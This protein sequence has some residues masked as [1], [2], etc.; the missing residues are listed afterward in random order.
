M[1]DQSLAEIIERFRELGILDDPQIAGETIRIYLTEADKTIEA[2]EE[3]VRA[4]EAGLVERYAHKLRGGALNLGA[5]RL[6]Q[7][8]GS[9]EENGRSGDLSEAGSRSGQIRAEFAR[10]RLFLADL[11]RG[12][13][14]A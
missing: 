8:A 2:L 12:S 1:T 5:R 4:S 11:S 14:A 7:L 13:A 10:L 9:L 3:A 6:A